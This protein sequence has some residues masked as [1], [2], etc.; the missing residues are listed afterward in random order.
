MHRLRMATILYFLKKYIA[1][2][3]CSHVVDPNVRRK[4]IIV[5]HAIM[6]VT[7]W[8]FKTILNANFA[9]VALLSRKPVQQMNILR[10]AYKITEILLSDGTQYHK[11]KSYLVCFSSC[12]AALNKTLPY[13]TSTTPRH[14]AAQLSERV[15]TTYTAWVKS[16]YTVYII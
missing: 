15:V 16:R 6:C 10:Q 5:C 9:A 14:T 1:S 3:I 2:H 4:L 8:N 11:Y 13:Y 7:Q 12:H